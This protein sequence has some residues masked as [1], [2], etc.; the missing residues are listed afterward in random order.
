[1]LPRPH[2][3]P[4]LRRPSPCADMTRVRMAISKPPHIT[5]CRIT[6]WSMT[7]IRLQEWLS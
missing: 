4:A 6:N 3:T 7:V 5:H 2:N 1:M